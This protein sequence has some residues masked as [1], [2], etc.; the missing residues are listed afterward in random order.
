MTLTLK[1]ESPNHAVIY[2]DGKW[3]ATVSTEGDKGRAERVRQALEIPP[4]AQAEMPPCGEVK[5]TA[6]GNP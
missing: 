6:E 3:L 1:H 4:A 5:A 2:S